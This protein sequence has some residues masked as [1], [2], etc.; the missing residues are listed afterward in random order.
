M[1]CT[2]DID[3]KEEQAAWDKLKREL[4]E[5]TRMLCALCQLCDDV[6]LPYMISG[7]KEWWSKHKESDAKRKERLRLEAL[8]KLTVDECEA[9]GIKR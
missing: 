2:Y 9:L 5:T 4:D 3:P 8:A 6:K 1:P 7:L